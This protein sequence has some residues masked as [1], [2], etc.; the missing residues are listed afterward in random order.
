MGKET[1]LELCLQGK[2]SSENWEK[3]VNENITQHIS[4]YE[5]L[6]VSEQDFAK[7]I[8]RQHTF[9]YYVIRCQICKKVKCVWPGA[10]IAFL[11]E[12]DSRP[13]LEFGW[14]DVIDTKGKLCKVQCDDNFHGMRAFVIS[15]D[16]IS[17]ILPCKERPLV[18]YKTM[19]CNECNKCDRSSNESVPDFCA[20][21]AFFDAILDKQLA[22][23]QFLTLYVQNNVSQL[24]QAQSKGDKC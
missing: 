8:Q 7:L 2:A 24:H 11:V 21:K 1:F 15:I 3:Y 16:D 20:H 18:Y 4:P 23:A 6:G 12:H 13:H 5:L 9:E 19:L 10:Y 14:V 22:D 17:A